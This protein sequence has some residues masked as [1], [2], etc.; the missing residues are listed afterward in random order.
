MEQYASSLLERYRRVGVLI[1]TNLLLLCVIGVY[2]PR[3]IA[4]F[5]RTADRFAPED[6]ETLRR[7]LDAFD[8]VITTPHVLTEVSNLMG[9]LT[10]RV[11]DGCFEF[12]SQAITLMHEQSTPA[13]TLRAMHAFARFGLTDTAIVDA[14]RGSYLVLT[15]DLP[16]AAYLQGQ[17]VDVLNFN[18]I[19]PLGYR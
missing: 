8:R 2:D 15:D 12:F 16:L 7:V 10:G 19:R 9:R 1:D 18:N 6:F 13:S 17:G 4:R 5:G 11:R 3:Q 14:A